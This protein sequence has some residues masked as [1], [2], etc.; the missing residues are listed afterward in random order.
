MAL[1]W[2][3][4]ILGR[5]LYKKVGELHNPTKLKKGAMFESKEKLMSVVKKVHITNHQEIK[6]VKSD[7]L[8]W[9][10]VC[11][12]NNEGCRWRLRVR[13]RKFHNFFEIM[14]TEG[15][16]TCLKKSITQDHRNLSSSLIAEIIINPYC[17]GSSC[18]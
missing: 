16:H 5:I 18:L 9:E 7:T 13:K 3:T 17:R 10:V 2:L 1:Q 12:Q 15:P 11:K 6:V 4:Q 8:T 14:K